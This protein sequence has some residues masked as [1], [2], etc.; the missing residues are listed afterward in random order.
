MPNAANKI[1]KTNKEQEE[2]KTLQIQVVHSY[3]LELPPHI[4]PGTKIVYGRVRQA[5]ASVLAQP[6]LKLSMLGASDG[7]VL[8]SEPLTGKYY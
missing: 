2:E 5:A 1:S 4:T 8:Y 6:G 3:Q 7:P